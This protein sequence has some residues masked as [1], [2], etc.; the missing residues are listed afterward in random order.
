MTVPTDAE[1]LVQVR[2]DVA[3]MKG[4][5]TTSVTDH[6]RR[7]AALEDWNK[8]TGRIVLALVITAVLGLVIAQPF[9]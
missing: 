8:W 6:E 4:M 2:V 9:Q 7:I 3:E 5:L 1:N